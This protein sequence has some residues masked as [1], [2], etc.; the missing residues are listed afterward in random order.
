MTRT[1]ID[2]A[3]KT[4]LSVA[5]NGSIRRWRFALCIMFESSGDRT[6]FRVTIDVAVADS[7]FEQTPFGFRYN[8]FGHRTKTSAS[9][10]LF[11]FM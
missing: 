10:S 1:A 3:Q 9:D 11:C 2:L 8:L 6:S 7:E 5:S 4:K